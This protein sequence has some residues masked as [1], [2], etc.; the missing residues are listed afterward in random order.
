LYIQYI[1]LVSKIYTLDQRKPHIALQLGS[2][3][4]TKY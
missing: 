4:S 2:I 3:V 1:I